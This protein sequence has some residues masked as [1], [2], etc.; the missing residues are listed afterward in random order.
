MIEKWKKMLDYGG[1]FGALLTDLPRT[2]HCIPHDLFIKKLE[3]YSFQTDVLNLV[4]DYLPN[5]KQRAKIAETFSCWKDIKYGVPRGSILSPLLFNIH[6][7]DL[8]YFFKD[9]DIA[10]Y[11]DDTT[12]YAVKKTKRLLLIH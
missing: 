9:L 10:S 11:A 8:F 1:V 5:R 4:Y 6:L 12:I 7:C 3:A 2:F